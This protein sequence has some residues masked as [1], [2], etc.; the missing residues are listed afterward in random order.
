MSKSNLDAE[1]V[2]FLYHYPFFSQVVYTLCID[3]FEETVEEAKG[4]VGQF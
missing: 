2:L 1:I 4:L 3:S